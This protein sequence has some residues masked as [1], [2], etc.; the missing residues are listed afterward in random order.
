MALLMPWS[1]STNVSDGQIFCRNSSRW[2]DRARV[3][4]QNPEDVE[5]LLLQSDPGSIFFAQF[6]RLLVQ[7]E[8]SEA[9]DRMCGSGILH[10]RHPPSS[11]QSLA[12]VAYGQ[13]RGNSSGRQPLRG[14]VHAA[15]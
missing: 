6:S 2:D 10:G 14:E 1:K 9:K 11:Q 5:W 15:Q 13:Q 12:S 7:L 3:F 4:Q 8:A